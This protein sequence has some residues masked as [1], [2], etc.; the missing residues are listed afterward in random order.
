[1][2]APVALEALRDNAR[3]W[4]V[5]AVRGGMPDPSGLAWRVGLL[6][7]PLLGAAALGAL[8]AGFAQT[9]GVFSLEPLRWD[10]ERLNPL[11]R[12][13]R[14]FGAHA[15]T[16]SLALAGGLV[17]IV[18]A[19][20]ILRDM[21]EVLAHGVGDARAASSLAVESCRRLGL[22]ALG[23]TLAVAGADTVFRYG[24]WL[25]RQR[26]TPDE[27]RR[28]RREDQGDPELSQAR[29]RV[30]RELANSGAAREMARA[31]L[32]VLG[33]PRLAVALRYDPHRDV[34][35]RVVLRGSGAVAAS[36]E[37]LAA[38]HGVPIEHD[39]T[40]ARQLASVPLDQEIPKSRYADI[41]R[42]L[43]RAGMFRPP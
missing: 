25:A 37:A 43:Q 36:L 3:A 22:W 16:I 40:L 20:F 19:V 33:A 1:V 10:L 39:T 4:L 38:S 30:H 6:A 9:R 7:G 8:I 11:T 34:A 32:L 2:F 26:M 41:A 18:A 13:R 27:V 24:E 17:L 14:T 23:V 42:A 12:A 35:P 21:G 31:N 29:Q 5:E 28:E 15:F